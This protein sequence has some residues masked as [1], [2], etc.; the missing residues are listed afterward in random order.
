MYQVQPLS[1]L[2]PCSFFFVHGL[3]PVVIEII[4]LRGIKPNIQTSGLC[5]SLLLAVRGAQC[6]PVVVHLWPLRGQLVFTL[7][8]L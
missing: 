7:S 4:P 6:T 5:A 8:L 1:G 3:T 2:E